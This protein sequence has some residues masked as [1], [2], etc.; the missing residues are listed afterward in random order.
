MRRDKLITPEVANL[1]RP[2]FSGATVGAQPVIH[3]APAVL[4]QPDHAVTLTWRVG[5]DDPHDIVIMGPRTQARYRLGQPGRDC[6]QLRFLPGRAVDFLGLPLRELADRAV[7]AADLDS[8]SLR[9]FVQAIAAGGS[10]VASQSHA[11][12][13]RALTAALPDAPS[14]HS[15]RAALRR[16]IV[17]EA[18]ALLSIGDG[19]PRESVHRVARRLNVSERHLRTV[20]AD[21]TGLTPS[22]FVRLDRVRAVLTRIQQKLPEVST[23]AG[24]YDQSHMTA[25]FHRV[26]GVTPSA[27]TMRRW[28]TTEA[29][30]ADRKPVGF[31]RRAGS[32]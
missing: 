5:S 30:T 7:A 19:V 17:A 32:G 11:A 2:W 26:M 8:T 4:E 1:L 29:C 12:R 18:T 15:D 24:Y 13:L 28:P 31:S 25:E 9:T 21:G 23:T 22:Q 10:Q 6:L 14:A 3:D 16:H 27:F 20:F